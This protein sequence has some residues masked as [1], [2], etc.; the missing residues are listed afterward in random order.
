MLVVGTA[1][2][3]SAETLKQA[4]NAAYKFNPRLDAARANQRATDEE[5]PRALSGYRPRIDGSADT[6]YEI[7]STLPSGQ[8]RR[9]FEGNPRG[10]AV[11]LTQPIFRGFRTK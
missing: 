3:A 2:S 8:P 4:L 1:G 9:T 5:V 10:Y 11:G 7:Q 6:T